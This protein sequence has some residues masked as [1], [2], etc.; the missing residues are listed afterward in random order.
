MKCLTILVPKGPDCDCLALHD[1]SGNIW[2]TQSKLSQILWNIWN[3]KSSRPSPRPSPKQWWNISVYF[4]LFFGGSHKDIKVVFQIFYV[5]LSSQ[6]SSVHLFM[7]THQ[8]TMSSLG[9][10][11]LF[12]LVRI[13]LLSV[14]MFFPT[15]HRILGPF[16]TFRGQLDLRIKT[17]AD[18]EVLRLEAHA[19]PVQLVSFPTLCKKQLRDWGLGCHNRENLWWG[20]PLVTELAK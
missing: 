14:N 6:L 16:E 17:E 13:S 2:E 9:Q 20:N 12:L 8:N 19:V 3:L 11:L 1:L 18:T 4:Y 5:P 15:K 10:F 7:T